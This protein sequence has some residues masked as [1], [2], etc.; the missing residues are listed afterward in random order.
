MGRNAA[1]SFSFIV[2]ISSLICNVKGYLFLLTYFLF[3]CGITAYLILVIPILKDVAKMEFKSGF[4]FEDFIENVH[5]YFYSVLFLF[6]M[7]ITASNILYFYLEPTSYISCN[8]RSGK[9]VGLVWVKS[10]LIKNS[11]LEATVVSAIKTDG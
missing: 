6:V 7:G 3:V 11:N 1:L 9:R 5:K 10:F 2:I 8:D 4:G